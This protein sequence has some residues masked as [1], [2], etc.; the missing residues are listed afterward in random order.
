MLLFSLSGI[1][2]VETE[3]ASDRITMDVK[4]RM[5]EGEYVPVIIT[6][7]D[8]P[9]FKTLSKG[10]AVTLMKER[11]SDSQQNLVTLLNKE[12]SRGK[13]D[14]IK[15]FWIVNAIA[16]NASPELIEILSK[17]DD[18]ASIELDSELHILEDYSALVSQG[19]IDNATSEIKYINTTKVWELGIDGSGINVSVI[20][21]GINAAHPDIAGRVVKW[22]DYINGGG[23]A[24]D[25][26]P[27]GHGT[28][29]AGTVGGNGS[30][31]ITTGVAP[32]VSLFGVKVLNN[33]GSGSASDMISGI[34]W[35]VSNRADV[36]SMSLGT[37]QTWMTPDCDIDNPAIA[38]AIN[39]AVNAGIVV[40]AAAGNNAS[41]VSSPGCI[42]NAIAVG[43]VD[44]SDSI[45]YF[46]GRGAAM[47]DHGV[48]APGVG[49]TSLNLSNGYVALSG[50]SMATPHV[51]GMVALLLHAAKKNDLTLSPSQIK[52]ILE[53]TSVDLGTAGKDDTYGAGRIN[54]F[55]AIAPS[56]IANPTGYQAGSAARNGTAV[57][58]NATITD[59]IAGVKNASVNV[60][61]INASITNVSLSSISGFWVNDN[62][63]VNASDGIYDLNVTAYNNMGYINNLIQLSIIVD[64]TPPLISSA[65]ATPSKIEAGSGSSILSVNVTD[66]LSGVAQV[67]VNLSA[68]GGSPG[69][70]M[71]NTGGDIWQ[72]TVNTTAVGN[73][74]LS[75]N[76]TDGAGNI[77]NGTI[78]LS[79]T[80]LTPPVIESARAT[81][82]SIRADGIDSTTLEIITHDF[83]DVSSIKNVTVDLTNLGGNASQEME[84]SSGIWRFDVTTNK[85]GINGTL[86]RLPVNV[87]DARD[88][89]NTSTS[90]LLGIK[91]TINASAGT[92]RFNFTIDSTIF[93]A[94]IS[95]PESTDLSGVLLVAPVDIPALDGLKHAGV[96]LNLSNLTFDELIRIEMQYNFSYF[97]S[98]TEDETKLRLWFYN[99]TTNRWEITENSSVDTLNRTVS[100]YTSHFSVFAPLADVTPPVISNIT[101]TSVTTGSAII[102]WDTDKPA[103]S[104]VKYGTTEGSYTSNTEDTSNVTS[105]SVQLAGLSAG[106]TYYYI[107]IST[108]HSGNT[109]NVTG[110]L[111]TLSG[112]G[113]SSSSG[114]GG[115]GG[116]GVASAEDYSNIEVKEKYDKYI[117]KDKITSYIFTSKNNPVLFVN[118]TG[119]VN[120]GEIS[121]AVEVLRNPS[122]IVKGPAPGIA[123]KNIN[124]W[125]GTSGFAVPKNIK[126]ADITFR[127]E[128]Q[129]TD[130]VDPGSIALYRYDSQWIKLPTQKLRE[131]TEFEYYVASTEKFSPFAITILRSAE[132]PISASVVKAGAATDGALIETTTM[133]AVPTEKA[134][135]FEVTL[136]VI[137]LCAIYLIGRKRR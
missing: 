132:E 119:N 51:S 65:S 137:T 56:V 82:D 46:S 77:E 52:S 123:Y 70:P 125:V 85:T 61:S 40:V 3:A 7:K 120:A 6:L 102:S 39:N 74:S 86:I 57:I 116:G 8:S 20:D 2:L 95:I 84:N 47:I 12:R 1:F 90:I 97:S 73:F 103:Q 37:E 135:G 62:V 26:D 29:V 128:K 54:V 41:G 16:V 22:V 68:I 101:L 9:S 19:Q 4:S 133:T 104:L 32:N 127:V 44:S 35:S 87:T 112:G 63:I 117:F 17:R 79:V 31:G 58:L 89:S 64:N 93:N 45:A 11:A 25:D 42:R 98:F 67:A 15:Q 71:Q 118:I 38:Y 36:I 121:A 136:A 75:V 81:P 113:A 60:S 50:T 115:G 78:L 5:L 53:T 28:H 110:S 108:D 88:N 111:T 34:E 72:I 43:A 80:D 30:L 21:T 126:N 76:A 109:A 49:V 33:K 66:N 92:L 69:S 124:I 59:A 94:S 106:T 10:D 18:V 114:G 27:Y 105:H 24:Y 91:E 23:S 131:D 96:A 100:G 134:P 129:W 122:S 99:T 83:A 13:A 55:A 48:V 130:A 14:K 107:V